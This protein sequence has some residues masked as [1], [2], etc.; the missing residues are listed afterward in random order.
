MTIVGE[1]G[2]RGL[3]KG[4]PPSLLREASYS[5]I[6]MGLYEQFKVLFGAT[7]PAHTPLYKKVRAGGSL[8]SNSAL[9][10]ASS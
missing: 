3:Y 4:L 1:E 2:V 8:H 7:D 9:Q 10:I 6:R 5:A